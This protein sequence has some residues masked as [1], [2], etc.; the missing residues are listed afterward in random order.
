MIV[1]LSLVTLWLPESMM[2]G[3]S[4]E[5]VVRIGATGGYGTG[6]VGWI[7]MVRLDAVGSEMIGDG[8]RDQRNNVVKR[9][10][11]IVGSSEW[12]YR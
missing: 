9:M 1:F 11:W 3:F 4:K 10:L 6:G 8:R 7:I 5:C 2:L 12:D